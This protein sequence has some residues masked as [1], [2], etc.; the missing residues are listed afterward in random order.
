M[1]GYLLL[2]PEMLL[3]V[4]VF[5]ALFA[6]YLPG[7][8]RGAAVVG[9]LAAGGATVL[10]ALQPVGQG[11]F[12]D[13]LVFDGASRFIRIAIAA[14]TALWMLW[15]AGRD[16]G[17]MRE[18]VAVGALV[19]IGSMLMSGAQELI[20]LLVTLELATMP[21][22]VLIGYRRDNRRSLEGALK[23]F[24]LSMTTSLVMLYGFSLLYGISGTTFIAGL[25]SQGGLLPLIASFF[26]FVGL[27]AKL[28]AAP[29]HYWAPDAYEGADSW[30]VSFVATIPKMAALLVVIRFTVA[31]AAGS[32]QMSL[33]IAV[34]AVA[35]MVLGNLA[36]LGQRDVRRIMA[37]SGVAQIGYVLV[38]LVAISEAS[39]SAAL[40]YIVAYSVATMGILLAFGDGEA[41]LVRLAGL[42]RRHPVPA[43]AATVLLFSLI[44]LP[45]LAGFMGKFYLF[46]AAIDLGQLALVIVAIVTSIISA[47]YYLRIV[48]AMFFDT[49]TDTP[50]GVS[51]ASG[52]RFAGLVV[53]LCTVIALGLGIFS[54]TVFDFLGLVV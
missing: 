47:A 10:V 21:A 26:V 30:A 52:S 54:S 41:A 50:E 36:A 5:W 15:V 53:V 49:E 45:P 32:S 24:L 44:G 29:F 9:L 23:Y 40:F 16:E 18:A 43:V 8:D 37:Y 3:L 38:G 11:V 34:V 39:I 12:G 35:S 22:Y 48:K 33:L 25:T 51:P 27:F 28:S 4:A 1:T 14:L 13:L 31:L 46:T 20:T 6:E 7:K 17:R 42:G 2:L 19:S